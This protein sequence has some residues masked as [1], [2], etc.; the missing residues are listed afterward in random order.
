[1]GNEKKL[2]GG[3]SCPPVPFTGTAVQTCVSEVVSNHIFFFLLG[4][5]HQE[6]LL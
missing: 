1:M 3:P 6:M 2:V 5:S 4:H